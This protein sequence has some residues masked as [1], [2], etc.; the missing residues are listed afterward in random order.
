LRRLIRADWHVHT[1][2]S[3]CGEPEATPEAMVRAAQ[4]AGLEALG[5]ADHVILPR[6]RSR[7][8]LVRERLP[9][10]VDGLRL[11]FGCEAD[12]QS[13]T[14]A[15]ITR[16]FAADLDYVI[17]SASHLYVPGVERP[18]QLEPRTM[19]ALI[20]SLTNGAIESGLADV[21]AH[22][23]GVPESPFRFDEIV[24]KIDEEALLRTGEAAARAGVAMEF[25]P[26]Y[27][28]HQ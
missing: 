15:T 19:A 21:I 7:P 27:L 12:M 9:G 26:R 6:H 13:P 2:Y 1:A 10:Q 25:N 20:I 14:R 23:F 22:P 16:E 24:S 4:E 5:F 17:M 3:D 18:A 28:R 11:Y 8:Q